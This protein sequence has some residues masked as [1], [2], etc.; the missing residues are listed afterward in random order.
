MAQQVKILALSMQVALVAAMV[1]VQ[2][3][4]WELPHAVGAAKKEKKKKYSYTL[5]EH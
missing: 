5:A 3:L 1:Q 2:P 4:A